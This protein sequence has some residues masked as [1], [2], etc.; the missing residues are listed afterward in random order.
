MSLKIDFE[1][2]NFYRGPKTGGVGA[3]GT[4]PTST[5]ITAADGN[6]LACPFSTDNTDVTTNHT[7]DVAGTFSA[8]GYNGETVF[9]SSAANTSIDTEGGSGSGTAH[10]IATASP[11]TFGGMFKLVGSP[12]ATN[13]YFLSSAETGGTGNHNYSI[14]LISGS[15]NLQSGA[16]GTLRDFNWNPH[17]APAAADMANSSGWYHIVMQL[18]AGRSTGRLFIDGKQFGADQV[19][20]NPGAPDA[21]VGSDFFYVHGIN[22]VPAGEL[23][24]F[25]RNVF[26][27]DT[28]MT[29]ATIRR[30]AEES[31]GHGLPA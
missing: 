9:N 18:E 19:A 4:V 15:L 23:N 24:A 16:A 3:I 21:G 25:A 28:L 2:G 29:A 7:F 20:L 27:T 30:L 22:G 12:Q 26:I 14:V 10:K 11:V 1:P 6:I 8:N 31:Y 5:D 17:A 13:P